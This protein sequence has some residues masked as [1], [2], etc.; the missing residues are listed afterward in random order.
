MAKSVCSLRGR[1][2]LV[3]ISLHRLRQC[4]IQSDSAAVKGGSATPRKN[5]KATN[6]VPDQTK[7]KKKVYQEKQVF[8]KPKESVWA[9]KNKY[10]YQSKTYAPRQSLTSCFVLRNNRGKVVAKYVE[11]ETN[12]YRN[13]S[14]WVPKILVTNMQGL[15]SNWGPKSS[16]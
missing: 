3:Q 13:T 4:S 16:N 5:G 15:K 6:S 8:Q 7:P 14:I 12:I 2:K 10:A 1:A 11:K 9:T